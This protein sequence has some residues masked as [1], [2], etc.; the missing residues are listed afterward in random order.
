M[1][2]LRAGALIV[3][4]VV[5]LAALA[6]CSPVNGITGTFAL[7][8]TPDGLAQEAMAN[9]ASEESESSQEETLDV[10]PTPVVE[11]EIAP[12]PE[13]PIHGSVLD[14]PQ[15]KPTEDSEKEDPQKPGGNAGAEGDGGTITVPETPVQPDD[16]SSSSS[17]SESGASGEDSG[18][19][20][21]GSTSS[22]SRTS[23]SGSSGGSE[24]PT[25]PAGGS[26]WVLAGGNYYCYSG[27]SLLTGWK[28]V[29]G[30]GYYFNESGQL[31]SRMGIDV[32]KWQKNIDWAKVKADGV[33]FAIIRAGVR[34]SVTG[35]KKYDEYFEQN[36]KGALANGIQV[37][38]YFFSQAIN[39]DEGRQEAEWI[40][41]AIQGYNI[42]GPVV[43]D[44]EYASW[45]P[46]A[47]DT[48]PR[49]NRISSQ[50]RTEVIKAFCDTVA[51]AGKTPMIYSSRSWFENNMYLSQLTNYAKWN[52]EWSSEPHLS[53][54]F[55]IWQYRSD[56]TVDGISGNVDCNAWITSNTSGLKPRMALSA[57]AALTQNSFL[58]GSEQDDPYQLTI[59]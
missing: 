43:I 29:N 2:K 59:G 25:P 46:G 30:H 31:S 17:S 11:E 26:G 38:V 54:P 9:V 12:A 36:V 19:G 34:G 35:E 1:F 15:F 50:T 53:A 7:V 27:G 45:N 55:S 56:G 13:Q 40:L 21:G 42:T 28:S 16:S 33:D 51:A 10:E 23:D 39:A 14:D 5:A 47:G 20:S 3:S 22:D 44:S 24:L 58:S 48:E 49:G 6:G 37:G 32:S 41:N 18:E 4:A 52:A 8:Y 57:L